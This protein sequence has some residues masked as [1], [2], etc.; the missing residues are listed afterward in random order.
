M[1]NIITLRNLYVINI[2]WRHEQLLYVFFE[3][4]EDC[5]II[6]AEEAVE[7]YGKCT[8]SYFNGNTVVLDERLG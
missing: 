1:N 4:E 7:K 8:V 6:T 2:G 5:E 3:R